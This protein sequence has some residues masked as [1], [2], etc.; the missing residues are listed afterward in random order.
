MKKFKSSRIWVAAFI[1][2]L[3]Y[4]PVAFL[5]WWGQNGSEAHQPDYYTATASMLVFYSLVLIPIFYL[6]LLV[7]NWLNVTGAIRRIRLFSN[8]WL[9]AGFLSL[10][11]TAALI[12]PVNSEGGF[13]RNNQSTFQTYGD[14]ITLFFTLFIL[15]LSN[16]KLVV[17]HLK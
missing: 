1:T 8:Y 3:L 17:D 4:L 2:Y 16:K 12:I 10:L 15:F 5:V 13:T 11:I 7:A 9:I 6:I 14:F